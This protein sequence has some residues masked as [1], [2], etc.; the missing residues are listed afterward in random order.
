ML[1]KCTVPRHET[2]VWGFFWVCSFFLNFRTWYGMLL[3]LMRKRRARFDVCFQNHGFFLL[4]WSRSYKTIR[5]H[6]QTRC[7]VVLPNAKVFKWEA[8]F[9]YFWIPQWKRMNYKILGLVLIWSSPS[10]TRQ[11]N[12]DLKWQI[13]MCTIH[14]NRRGRDNVTS[15]RS[16][17]SHIPHHSSRRK[18]H[19]S[20][21]FGLRIIKIGVRT[22]M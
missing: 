1:W 8:L 7:R 22:F 11:H 13:Y 5:S 20:N 3:K 6:I 12:S 16:A 19:L 18:I 10:N 9:F 14:P 15:A 2:C 4:R 21:W 17:N